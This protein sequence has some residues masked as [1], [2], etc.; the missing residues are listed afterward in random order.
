MSWFR[1]LTLSRYSNG[2]LMLSYVVSWWRYKSLSLSE[3]LYGNVVVHIIIRC[4]IWSLQLGSVASGCPSVITRYVLI[5]LLRLPIIRHLLSYYWSLVD[6]ITNTV[7][8]LCTVYYRT[9]YTHHVAV[10][11]FGCLVALMSFRGDVIGHSRSRR[12]YT[13]MQLTIRKLQWIW[14]RRIDAATKW[15]VKSSE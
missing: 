15:Q 5:Y 3:A 4:S 12:R 1:A 6:D 7:L 10:F 8:Y 9:F 2:C 11:S 14:E 13:V